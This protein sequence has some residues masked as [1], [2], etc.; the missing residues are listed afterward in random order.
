M[1]E[2]ISR[3]SAIM[4]RY[5]PENR[6][7]L[8]VDEWGTWYD[9]EPGS[10]PGFLYQQ[11]TIRDAA[12]AA[13]TLNIFH[14]HTER[15]K[16]ANIAQMVNVL[17]AMILTDGERMVLTP[18]YHIFDMYQ[19]F[20]DATPYPARVEG[21]NYTQGDYEIPMVDVSAARGSDGKLYLALVNVDPN[22]AARIDTSLTG[23][24]SGRILTGNELDTHNSFD[25]PDTI[26]PV[27]FQGTTRGG[28]L[29]FD[30]PAKSIAVVAVE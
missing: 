1:E 26:Q 5:D 12:V 7:A 19:P 28:R 22:R 21:P 11:N 27:A 3:H 14:R 25:R 18:T 30:L 2:L 9:Q 8:Y 6:V 20:Q 4:E 23:R 15:V 13:L 16:M 17:Q 29:A 10:T 24:A